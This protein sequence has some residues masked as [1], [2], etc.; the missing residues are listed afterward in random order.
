MARF[1]IDPRRS[2]VWIDARSNV[3]PIHTATDGLEGWVDVTPDGRGGLDLAV[4]P[5]GVLR[6]PVARLSSGNR[7]EDRELHKRI[8]A[9]RHPTIDGVLTGLAPADGD[10]RYRVAGDLTFCGVTRRCEDVMVVR[11]V[12]DRTLELS[13]SSTFDVRE[14]GVQPPRILL[15]RVEPEVVVRVEITATR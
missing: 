6:L 14:F 13:G 11:P 7:L 3:H 12:D 1:E 4:A 10:G 9:A 8:D 5:S 2:R 15:L